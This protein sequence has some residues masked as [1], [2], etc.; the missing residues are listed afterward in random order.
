MV[1]ISVHMI[2]PNRCCRYK[3]LSLSNST[4]QKTDAKANLGNIEQHWM[5]KL[6]T[7]A[8][9]GINSMD[10]LNHSRHSPN[11]P[12]QAPDTLTPRGFRIHK[13]RG[14]C[15]PF[16][17]LQC[18]ILRVGDFSSFH[19]SKSWNSSVLENHIPYIPS[20]LAILWLL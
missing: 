15:S 19:Y 2:I 20:V 3:C 7:L 8:P 17:C 14:Q 12:R 18:S 1:F 4:P 11:K 6:K 13:K 16:L 10:V 9:F 5:H